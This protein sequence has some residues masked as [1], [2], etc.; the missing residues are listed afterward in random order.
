MRERGVGG[1]RGWKPT[2]SAVPCVM[3]RTCL[4]A[5]HTGLPQL[6]YSATIINLSKSVFTLNLW[7]IS[8]QKHPGDDIICDDITLTT[9]GAQLCYHVTT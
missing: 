8:R 7:G 2:K 3:A 5:V 9:H 4:D 1:R 6:T